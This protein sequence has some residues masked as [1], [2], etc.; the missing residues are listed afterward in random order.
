MNCAFNIREFN[1][2]DIDIIVASFAKHHWQKPRSI[3][4]SYLNEQKQGTRQ[5]WVAWQ[6]DQLVGYATLNWRSS[7]EP[8][9]INNIPEI[10][11]LNVLPPYRKLGIGSRLIE[12]AENHAAKGVSTIGIG[13]GLYDG[14]GNAQRLYV[15]HGYIPDGKGP[16]YRYA[17]LEY[18]QQVL[19]DDD[20]VLWFT[21]RLQG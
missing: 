7:Y 13:V 1:E 18:G 2:Q 17:K 15:Q 9:L 6:K 3:F 10:M 8:F 16:T 19:V 5:I 21:K 14:Y 4:E 12:I 20:L 11:D